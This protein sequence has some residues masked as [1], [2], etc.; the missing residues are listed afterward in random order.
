MAVDAYA[1]CGVQKYLPV[2]SVD[3]V[4][5]ATA[6]SRA[7]LCQHLGHFDNSYIAS[8]VR[9]RPDRFAGVALID[10][11]DE[12]WPRSLETV[13]AQGF[14]GVR[15]TGESLE[16]NPN[17][18]TAVAASG[19]VALVYAPDGIAPALPALRALAQAHPDAP[20]VIS[21]L[22]NPRVNGDTLAAGEEILTLAGH[23][24][25]RVLLSGPGMF[26]PFPYT[27]LAGL[28]GL[29]IERFGPERVMWG[30]NFPVAGPSAEDY[31][32][33]LDLLR[34]GAWGVDAVAAEAI[35]GASARDLWFGSATGGSTRA[36]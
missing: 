30:S 1:H 3:A 7:V 35:A 10:H 17:L 22:G 16:Q 36:A 23:P 29:V 11:A 14:R 6:V 34:S 31:G 25:V 8:V 21:H 19:L 2:E 28:V 26:C 24:G 18:A 20:I 27:P 15:L 33:D 9:E 5:D 13:V 12:G 4:M 32:R